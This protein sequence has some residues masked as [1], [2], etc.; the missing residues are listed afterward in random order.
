MK[1]K[2]A[3][4]L[5]ISI[6]ALSSLLVTSFPLP[7]GAVAPGLHDTVYNSGSIYL[8]T[9][10]D[11]TNS[12]IVEKYDASSTPNPYDRS[13]QNLLGN[14]HSPYGTLFLPDGDL[15]A[16]TVD[17]A[18]HLNK[19]FCY[20]YISGYTADC[21][22]SGASGYAY[23]ANT[24]VTGIAAD[25]KGQIWAASLGA[26]NSGVVDYSDREIY[27]VETGETATL[28]RY[29]ASFSGTVNF[30]TLDIAVDHLGDIWFSSYYNGSTLNTKVYCMDAGNAYG[31]C[32]GSA[33]DVNGGINLGFPAPGRISIDSNDN[34]FVIT[35]GISHLIKIDRS[36]G[37]AVTSISLPVYSGT[38]NWM[39]IDNTDQVWTDQ[40]SGSAGSYTG[41]LNCYTASLTS[42]GIAEKSFEAFSAPGSIFTDK[43]NYVW[44]PID[45]TTTTSRLYCFNGADGAP[46]STGGNFT[47]DTHSSYYLTTGQLLASS[48]QLSIGD[49]TGTLIS[50]VFAA[51][52]ADANVDISATID[53]AISFQIRSADDTTDTSSCSLGSL[54][55][56]AVATCAYRLAVGT[57]ATGGYTLYLKADGGLVSGA[58]E[59]DAV[60]ENST[61]S[62]GVEGYG[63]AVDAA[64]TGFA[65]GATAGAQGDFTDND[66]PVPA[67][68]TALFNVDKPAAYTA[69][70][71]TD[72]TLI[73]HRAAISAFTP[74]GSYAQTITYTVTGNF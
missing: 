31:P 10:T 21:A 14:I 67:S 35:N 44:V 6:A 60:V 62:T 66:T 38:T 22:W 9:T 8:G 17:P 3:K 72:S 55:T 52:A 70:T 26:D 50:R 34:I 12:Y 59:I 33:F 24:F 41:K 19:L 16:L 69:L 4:S 7:T 32:T 27:R 63:I 56:G 74:A 2:R 45:K 65:A 20:T 13:T 73:T 43:N 64:T 54:S 40:Y 15:V 5:L 57:N 61:V 23:P 49:P 58:N 51:V 46:C 25:A 37:F 53:P 1:G 29:D 18:V 36:A 39:T 48:F 28:T 42:C 47:A 71:L 11:G 68:V 30:D